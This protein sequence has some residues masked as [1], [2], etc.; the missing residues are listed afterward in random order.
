MNRRGFLRNSVSF[1][2][3]V[4]VP[5][6]VLAV[7]SKLPSVAAPVMKS[8]AVGTD[9]EWDWQHIVAESSEVARRFFAYENGEECE[10][11]KYFDDG[12]TCEASMVSSERIAAWDGIED[13]RLTR[14]DWVQ[15]GFGANCNRCDWETDS[16]DIHLI[17]ERREIVCNDCLDADERKLIFPEEVGIAS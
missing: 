17:G 13:K 3:V 1:V 7:G 10:C 12:C 11:G 2:A 8:F 9:G 6:P 4:T 5:A 14:A 15:A 16:S